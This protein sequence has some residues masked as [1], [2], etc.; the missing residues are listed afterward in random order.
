MTK[1]ALKVLFQGLLGRDLS[2]QLKDP[3]T[4]TDLVIAAEKWAKRSMTVINNIQNG[5]IVKGVEVISDDDAARYRRRFTAFSGFCD[6]IANYT[7]EAKIKNFQ[8]S[9]DEVKQILE[10]KPQVEKVEK[11]L[12]E[13]L[14]W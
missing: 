14:S 2:K 1:A 3:S 11:Q 12:E 8:F 5:L 9:V 10:A 13:I 6:K 4:Y 7:S